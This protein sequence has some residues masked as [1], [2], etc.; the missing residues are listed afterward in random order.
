M[1]LPLFR[2]S[3]VETPAVKLQVQLAG[4]DDTDDTYSGRYR[5]H[6]LTYQHS[7]FFK[8][9]T[10][11]FYHFSFFCWR[12]SVT[13]HFLSLHTEPSLVFA[14]VLIAH[15]SVMDETQDP[16]GLNGTQFKSYEVALRECIPLMEN[17]FSSYDLRDLFVK[18]RI[19]VGGSHSTPEIT[20]SGHIWTILCAG[21]KT[22]LPVLSPAD[23]IRRVTNPKREKQDQV[24]PTKKEKQFYTTINRTLKKMEVTRLNSGSFSWQSKWKKNNVDALHGE[25]V[26]CVYNDSNNIQPIY[27]AWVLS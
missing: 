5:R 14:L 10:S 2:A 27:Q 26:A 15:S 18:C 1:A 17:E 6:S 4:A 20:I 19:K 9:T 3:V 11:H 21:K 25:A 13:E 24:E 16:C 23:L 22:V 8:L 7:F 12:Y